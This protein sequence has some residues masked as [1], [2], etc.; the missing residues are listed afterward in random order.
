MVHLR[1]S[2]GHSASGLGV[3]ME[4]Y[5]SRHTGADGGNS[6]LPRRSLN[7]R[8]SVRVEKKASRC[9]CSVFQNTSVEIKIESSI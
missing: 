5:G 8:F 9:S 3:I 2:P 6:R 1:H 4:W 7:V